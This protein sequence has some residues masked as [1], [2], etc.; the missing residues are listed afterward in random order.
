MFETTSCSCCNGP[1]I[2]GASWPDPVMLKLVYMPYVLFND[3]IHTH[4]WVLCPWCVC[5]CVWLQSP[6]SVDRREVRWGH[7]QAE[8]K[9]SEKIKWQKVTWKKSER[10]HEDTWTQKNHIQTL[11]AETGDALLLHHLLLHDLLVSTDRRGSSDNQLFT[12]TVSEDESCCW[13]E[14][15]KRKRYRSYQR[16]LLWLS[17]RSHVRPC[18]WDSYLPAQAF[19]IVLYFS[20]TPSL[21]LQ[22]FPSLYSPADGFLQATDTRVVKPFTQVPFSQ[23]WHRLS[24]QKCKQVRVAC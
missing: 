4:T 15:I 22:C 14:P 6:V 7:R 23:Y 17:A 5:V 10:T 18:V 20:L 13:Y 19:H 2:E 9:A 3:I 8:H 16:L 11:P 1:V 21:L 24:S 12:K